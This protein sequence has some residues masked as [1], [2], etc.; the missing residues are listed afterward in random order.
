MLAL[1]MALALAAGAA[2]AQI[3]W[4]MPNEYQATS[5]HGQGD[6]VFAR[7]LKER[8]GGKIEIAHHF[9]GA[10]GY[11]SKDQLD[12]VADGA[13]P[14][15]DTFL[16]PLGG[17]HP[18][19]L[20]A[21]LPFLAATPDET[22]ILYD[23]SKPYYD[24]AFT[25][26]NQKVLYSSPWPPSGLWAKKP[27]T[28]MA[29]LKGLKIRTYDASGTVTL[30]NAGAAPIQLSWADVIPQL[31]TGG[32]QAVLTSAEGGASAKFWEHL[33]HFTEINYASPL[34]MVT[35]NADTFEKL[36]PELKK[37]VLDSAAAA[38]AFTWKAAVTRVAEN[39][40]EMKK[41]GMTIVTGV[42]KD[43]LAELAKAGEEALN[44][45]MKKMGPDG[46]AIVTEYKKRLGRGS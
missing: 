22:R 29:E 46:T 4:D 35:I 28:S 16:G 9:G 19:F 34:N 11:K 39:Y 27:V 10:L 13:V 14:I 12:A 15:A 20:L 32:I 2:E 38:E 45:W 37:A 36:S 21:S 26:F 8:S 42:S 44:D 7:E 1:A 3:K 18:M 25:K 24:K 33:S 41:H 30:R 31:S 40:A 43:Y 5:L 17:V 23:V 6:V